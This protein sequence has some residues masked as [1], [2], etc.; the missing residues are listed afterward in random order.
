MGDIVKPEE[1]GSN[2]ISFFYRLSVFHFQFD[3]FHEVRP[4]Q[5]CSLL[6]SFP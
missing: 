1:V 5:R 2:A 3:Y 6:S 4:H